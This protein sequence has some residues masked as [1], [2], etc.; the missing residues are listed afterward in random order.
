MRALLF[1]LLFLPLANAEPNCASS[2]CYQP[3]AQLVPA[4][5]NP[6]EYLR[7]HIAHFN[8]WRR[9]VPD[10]LPDS[11]TELQKIGGALL[12]EAEHARIVTEQLKVLNVRDLSV[13]ISPPWP[14]ADIPF[15]GTIDWEDRNGQSGSLQVTG[16]VHLVENIFSVDLGRT[17]E[18]RDRFVR[19]LIFEDV[20][21]ARVPLRSSA[22]VDLTSEETVRLVVAPYL[23]GK[24]V[25]MARIGFNRLKDDLQQK[26]QDIVDDLK[27]EVPL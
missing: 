5:V 18:A 15:T 13:D 25:S 12:L 24:F 14:R 4:V 2:R 6:T 7:P 3:L 26:V 20:A 17:L 21:G 10:R 23:A 16:R 22:G 11:E 8:R 19:N 1:F 27:P 9:S